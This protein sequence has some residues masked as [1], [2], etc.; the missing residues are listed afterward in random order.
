[1]MAVYSHVRQKVLNDAVD[2]LETDVIAL[3]AVAPRDGQF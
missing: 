3:V 2:A 1:M